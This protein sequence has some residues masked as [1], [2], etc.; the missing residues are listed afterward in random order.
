MLLVSGAVKVKSL[1]AVER[2]TFAASTFSMF[3]RDLVEDWGWRKTQALDSGRS[4]KKLIYKSL[5]NCRWEKLWAVCVL[6]MIRA[7]KK[8]I[9]WNHRKMV[10]HEMLTIFHWKLTLILS[11]YITVHLFGVIITTWRLFLQNALQDISSFLRSWFEIPCIDW[12]Y[13]LKA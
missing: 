2:A 11:N 5:E 10:D 12:N 7:L 13:K 9:F 4:E 3:L 8:G 1:W 6:R